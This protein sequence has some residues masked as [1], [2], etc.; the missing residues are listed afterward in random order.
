M[1]RK[2]REKKELR[3]M[4]TSV[5]VMEGSIK[6]KS[7]RGEVVKVGAKGGGIKIKGV[8]KLKIKKLTEANV[9]KMT[10]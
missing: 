3:A 6:T 8:K 2:E 4:K 9:A 7:R 5:K 10:A 1:E